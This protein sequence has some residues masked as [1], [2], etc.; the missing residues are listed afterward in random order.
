MK[1]PTGDAPR[2]DIDTLNIRL[3]EGFRRRGEAIAR[4]TARHLSRM[5]LPDG[6]DIARLSVPAVTLSVGE[7]DGA[8]GRRI[9]RAIYAGIRR[10]VRGGSGRMKSGGH[11]GD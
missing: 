2:I 7:T 5:P 8:V 3:P 6:A 10:E 1:R 9:A 11:H 4:Q